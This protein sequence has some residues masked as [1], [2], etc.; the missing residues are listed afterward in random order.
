MCLCL[1]VMDRE[2]LIK[3]EYPN[4]ANDVTSQAQIDNRCKEDDTRLEREWRLY[5]LAERRTFCACW[6]NLRVLA[7]TMD[8]AAVWFI[9]CCTELCRESHGLIGPARKYLAVE[10][11]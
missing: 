5:L 6:D 7:N 1:R 8:G 9:I 10:T 4:P 2:E 3:R 11:D